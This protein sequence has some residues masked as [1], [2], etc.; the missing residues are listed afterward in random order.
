MTIAERTNMEN[1]V[2]TEIYRINKACDYPIG[3]KMLEC[4]EKAALI[5]KNKYP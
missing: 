4:Y 5:C 3:T 1:R 2:A